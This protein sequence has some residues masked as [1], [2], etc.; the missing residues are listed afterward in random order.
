MGFQGQLSSVQLADL[1]QTFYMNRQTGTL[2]VSEPAGTL[3][4][5]FDQGQIAL[6]TAPHVDG[7]PFLLNAL[8]RKGLL[9]PERADELAQDLRATNR[10]LRDICLSSGFIGEQEL[11]EI[12][13]WCIEELVCPLFELPE[14]DFTFTDGQPI[15]ELMWPEVIELGTTR[16]A[17]PQLVME[18]SRRKDEWRRIR[19]IIPDSSVLF[20][21]DNDGRANLRGV[22]TD[23][24]MLKV[25][26]YLDGRHTLDAIANIVGATRFDTQAIVAQ[27][28]LSGVARQQGPQD[29]VA[30][31][32]ELKEHGDLAKARELLEHALLQARLPE[33]MRPLAEV[34]SQL[35]HAAR[36]VELYLELIQMGQDQGNLEQAMQDLDVV[37]GLSPD[38]PEL[39]F[40]R[41]QLRSE[42]GQ[43]E[44]AAAGYVLAAQAFLGTKDVPRALDACH[45][46]KNLLPRSP[47]PHRYLARAYLMEGQTENATV[48]YKALWHALLTSHRPRHALEELRGILDSDCKFAAIKEQVLSHAQNSEAVKTSK[49]M[50]TLVYVV[51]C[52]V[53]IAVLV[54]GWEYYNRV[55]FRGTAR[56]RV[57]QLEQTL[58]RRLEAVEHRELI[59]EIDQLRSRYGGDSELRRPIDDLGK[60]V[61]NDFEA[62]ARGVLARGQ[63]LLDGG[64]FSGAQQAFQDLAIRFGGTAS[65]AGAAA[66]L[67]QVRQKRIEN[68]V[69]ADLSEAKRRW[70]AL[71]WDG[72]LAAIGKILERKDLPNVL[73]ARLTEE[74]VAWQAANTSSQALFER[75]SRIE[76]SG[77]QRAALQAF[78][79]ATAGEGEQHVGLARDHLR[80]LELSYARMIGKQL[81]DFAELGDDAKTF[82]AYDELVRVANEA[83]SDGVKTWLATLDIPYI[84]QVDVPGTVLNVRQAG[85]ETLIKA[86]SGTTGSWKHRLTY[87]PGETLVISASRSGFSTLNGTVSVSNRRSIGQIRLVRGPRWR[88]ELTGPATT[89]PV[90]SGM[91]VLIGTGRSTLEVVD[92]RQGATRPVSFP[93]SV[94]EFRSA[95]VVFQNRAYVV[96]EDSLA[97]VDLTTRTRLW[98]WPGSF[99]GSLWI[100]E[101]DLIQGT[102]LIV[103][104]S[105]TDGVAF[106]GADAYGRV[107]RYPFKHEG[108]LTGTPAADHTAN[109]TTVYLPFGNA[110]VVAEATAATEQSGPQIL[111]SLRTRGDLVGQPTKSIVGPAK[112]PVM[113]IGDSSGL[114]LAVDCDPNTPDTRRLVGSWPIDGTLPSTPQL[115]GRTAY[116][117]SGEG[118]LYACDLDTP[119]QIRWRFPTQG[120]FGQ[121]PG[122]PAIGRNGIY[123]ASSTGILLCIDKATGRERWRCDLGGSTSGGVIAGNDMVYVGMR[124]GHLLGL[125]EGA[126]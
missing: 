55:I 9:P 103:A 125:D 79:R 90:L 52:A 82:A 110:L 54:V 51:I 121:L 71:D 85:Q 96:I 118:R 46:A 100:Q 87:R 27:M 83:T 19:E 40:E 76:Q 8:M 92:A 41:A 99:T 3:H 12:S 120:T 73:R 5:Y 78:R 123:V 36:A 49:A 104:G 115:E 21:V 91:Q 117:T 47:E 17:T 60:R 98:S 57:A 35:G 43:A 108:D 61:N 20:I 84:L 66:M 14:G 109:R 116:V 44:E 97:A 86:P 77:D 94:A 112:R 56:E 50:R 113:L 23:A 81:Q 4:V 18:A 15:E 93:D 75:A 74:Q 48:E 34:C 30:D 68:L 25:L 58:P 2:S 65:A 64:E 102:Q 67:E 95:P 13:T 69:Q 1:F 59:E 29:A 70:Q 114:L 7:Q 16:L 39:H 37:I 122:E 22:Q 111:Y 63:A 101:H 88:A 24:E 10:P 31:A 53:S 124:S 45:R 33:V 62:R 89:P 38:D 105:A 119:G 106:L 26:R 72:A 11:D 32:M 42:M 80:N 107:S 6:C 126:E 28:I